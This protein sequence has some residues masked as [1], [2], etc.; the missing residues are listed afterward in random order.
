M[1]N[2]D[3]FFH[4][5]LNKTIQRQYDDYVLQEID[6]KQIRL[7]SAKQ[8]YL[9]AEKALQNLQAILAKAP[10][11]LAL[12]TVQLALKGLSDDQKQQ[13]QASKKKCEDHIKQLPLI[14]IAKQEQLQAA[15]TA[16]IAAEENIRLLLESQNPRLHRLLSSFDGG[17]L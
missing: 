10:E 2:N 1:S 5:N 11:N 3:S 8:H 7:D 13:L 17:P 15:T 6:Q 4:A 14:I 12:I 9:N 16:I